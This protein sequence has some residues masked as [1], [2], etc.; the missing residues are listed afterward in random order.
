MQGT[1]RH[2]T[3]LKG[4][5]STT[6]HHNTP[7]ASHAGTTSP[8]DPVTA[9]C[10]SLPTASYRAQTHFPADLWWPG[11]V[12]PGPRLYQHQ[13]S[14]PDSTPVPRWSTEAR[15][16]TL[17]PARSFCPDSIHVQS[18]ILYCHRPRWSCK[19]GNHL[20][21]FPEG[22]M[23]VV[24][25]TR[26]GLRA[27]RVWVWAAARVCSRWTLPCRAREE[28]GSPDDCWGQREGGGERC[29]GYGMPPLLCLSSTAA[30]ER[31][32]KKQ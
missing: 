8:R 1:T 7:T 23:F 15:R 12:P 13:G 27:G 16:C 30:R 21:P 6:R 28:S 18:R 17:D 22:R 24:M 9:R 14:C 19:M 29:G 25:G 4:T 3:A 2:Q 20:S 5:N 26:P 11:P 10:T 31:E 32:K